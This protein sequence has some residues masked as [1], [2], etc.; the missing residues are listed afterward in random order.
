MIMSIHLHIN[1]QESAFGAGIRRF[2][3]Y[4]D[5][6]AADG[7]GPRVS[8]LEAI[9][10]AGQVGD[11]SAVDPTFPFDPSDLPLDDVKTA[12][13]RNV[14]RAIDVNDTYRGWDDGMIV[15]SVH[16]TET[17]EFFYALRDAGREGVWQLDRFPFGEDAVEAARAGVR[18]TRSIHRALGLVDREGLAAAQKAQ[19]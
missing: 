12:L 2:G 5:R 1:I 19:D 17:F 14:L 18:V 6:Y 15:G 3:R 4:A 7:R 9:D 16:L 10:L 11:L 13:K 8:T